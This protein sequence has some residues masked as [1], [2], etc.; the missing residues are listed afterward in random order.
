MAS[1]VH[2]LHLAPRATQ[3]Q[4][5]V[6]E[7]RLAHDRGQVDRAIVLVERALRCAGDE[8]SRRPLV[9]DA[10][11]LRWFLDRD[12]SALRELRPFV[13]SML[14]GGRRDAPEQVL[15]GVDGRRGP[16]AADRA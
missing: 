3:L 15:R 12:G 6:L 11:W 10:A 7:A 16:G 14:V 9:P 1:V 13:M 5:W 2:D 4:G 8:E